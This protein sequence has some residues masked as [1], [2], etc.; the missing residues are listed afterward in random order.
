MRVCLIFRRKNPI[1]FSIENVFDAVKPFFNK[2]IQLDEITVPFYTNGILSIIRNVLF[3]KRHQRDVYH[4][5]GDTHYLVLGL[6]GRR[7]MLT[8][9][10]CVFMDH[11][12][13]FKRILF[14]YLFLKWP[15]KF[16]SITTTI[17]EKSRQDIIRYTGCSPDKVVVIPNPINSGFY[18]SKKVFK[19]DCPIL[20][21]IGS[22]PNKNLNRVIEAIKGINCILDIVGNIPADLERLLKE[23]HIQYRQSIKLSNE[24][25]VNKYI[26]CDIVLF[27]SIYEGFGLPIIEAQQTGRLVITSNISPMKEVAGDGA[28]L[29]DPFSVK[30]IRNGILEVIG[31][32][33]Y[34]EDLITKGVVNAQQYQPE[35]IAQQYMTLYKKML[36]DNS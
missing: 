7:T 30:A 5:T 1:F 31:N 15:V 14:K 10:D 13:R 26:E 11:P 27:P 16:S 3:V 36:S 20:L 24:Q 17:S 35:K 25:L 29:V 12:G 32:I 19:S 22:T 23:E 8:I 18:Y 6:P 28:C 34:R 9:H 4:V 33:A 21:F 2:Q